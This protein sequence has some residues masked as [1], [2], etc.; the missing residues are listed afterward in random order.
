MLE[1]VALELLNAPDY[2]ILQ[3]QKTSSFIRC[4]GIRFIHRC[5]IRNVSHSADGRLEGRRIHI[6]GHGNVNLH[7]VCHTSPQR[8]HR[9]HR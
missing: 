7:I 9:S 4:F 1:S 5:L 3:G 8:V 6:R 2:A